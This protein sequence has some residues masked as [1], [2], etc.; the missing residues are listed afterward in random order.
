MRITAPLQFFLFLSLVSAPNSGVSAAMATAAPS[1]RMDAAPARGP[2]VELSRW[3]ILFE[4]GRLEYRSEQR[5]KLVVILTELR[6]HSAEGES[7]ARESF[8]ALMTL[9]QAGMDASRTLKTDR[10]LAGQDVVKLATEEGERLLETITPSWISGEILVRRTTD[11]RQ[12]AAAALFLRPHRESAVQQGL[13]MCARDEAGIV[14]SAALEAL[15]GW[16]AVGVHTLF[17]EALSGPSE[18]LDPLLRGFAERHFRLVRMAVGSR[19]EARLAEYVAG[20]LESEDWRVA[21]RAVRASRGLDDRL[22]APALIAAMETWLARAEEDRPVR[23]VL[24]EIVEELRFRSG[25]TMGTHPSRW[26]SWWR[27][28]ATG[29]IPPREEPVGESVTRATFFGL[30]P[31]TDR[32]TFVIDR[33]A[34]MR[35]LFKSAGSGG[36]RSRYG[37][38]VEQMMSLLQEMGPSTEFNVV[39]FSDDVQ[40]WRNRLGKATPANLRAVRSWLLKR[41]PE[42]GTQLRI[43]LHRALRLKSNGRVDTERLE[44]DTLVVLCDGETSEGPSWVAPVLRTINDEARIVIHGVQIGDEG[45]GTLERLAQISGGRFVAVTPD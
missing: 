43:G 41:T 1:A 26:R 40:A 15:V 31:S 20:R 5:E 8:L 21:S 3:V 17:L 23:R 32:V 16:P 42:G 4:R 2:L 6:A 34:S 24:G 38:A 7:G 28:V 14:R 36:A 10:I 22:A 13:A 9:Y 37:E 27:A 35:A 39:L 19:S 33:S 18:Q 44:T 45:D 12:R 30:R 11:P 25:R 29:Q